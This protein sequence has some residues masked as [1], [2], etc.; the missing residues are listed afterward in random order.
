MSRCASKNLVCT[1]N[2]RHALDEMVSDFTESDVSHIVDSVDDRNY[3]P[4]NGESS[5]SE[6]SEVATPR[7][8]I[9]SA[10]GEAVG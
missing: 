7:S 8:L 5:G 9:H 1:P 10:R 6:S 4:E 2:Y 3:K